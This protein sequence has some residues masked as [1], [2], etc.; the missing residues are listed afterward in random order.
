[1]SAFG[2]NGRA[3]EDWKGGSGM[4]QG[5]WV[6]WDMVHPGLGEGQGDYSAG[7]NGVL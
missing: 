7:L 1:M 2:N 6:G 4:D 3:E 5:P